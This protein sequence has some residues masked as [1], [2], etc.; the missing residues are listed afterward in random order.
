MGAMEATPAPKRPAHD[1]RTPVELAVAT[2][3]LLVA[4][5]AAA[6]VSA[7]VGGMDRLDSPEARARAIARELS[8]PVCE[9]QS[10]AD[11]NSTVAAQ[12]RAE[13]GAM[14]REGKTESEIIDH[15][16]RQYGIWILARPPATGLYVLLWGAPVL[17][18][19]AGGYLVWRQTRRVA[20]T[21][22]GG[23]AG[24]GS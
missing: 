21:P 1:A 24:D 11:S 10:V 13:I 12:M 5:L 3:L 6:F 20:V 7:V 22:A 16:V 14:V 4:I 9:G 8:C 18:L 19:V 2:G 15:Y 17:I 23:K